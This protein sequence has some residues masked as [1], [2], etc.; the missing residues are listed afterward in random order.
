MFKLMG[1]KKITILRLKFLFIWR[2]PI[3]FKNESGIF[4]HSG[5]T[6]SIRLSFTEIILGNKFQNQTLPVKLLFETTNLQ[7][8]EFNTYQT[9]YQKGPG[10]PAQS[11]ASLLAD[12]GASPVPFFLGDGS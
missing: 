4:F 2:S 11:V 3:D 7:Q 9:A 5:N 10:P 8:S 1:K 12:P 6:F